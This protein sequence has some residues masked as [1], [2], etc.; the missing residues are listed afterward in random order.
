ML[1]L[2][3]LTTESPFPDPFEGLPFAATLAYWFQE[4]GEAFLRELLAQLGNP[5]QEFIDKAVKELALDDVDREC[6]EKFSTSREEMEQWAE[7]LAEMDLPHIAN[8]V[9]EAAENT[10]PRCNPFPENTADWRV[11]NRRHT[12]SFEGYLLDDDE[13]AARARALAPKAAK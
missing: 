10:P 3:M 9:L 12:G 7:E 5:Q 4:F 6:L 1:S 11:W 13:R 8:I 2:A